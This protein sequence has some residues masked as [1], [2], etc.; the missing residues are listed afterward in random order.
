MTLRAG[1]LAP[2]GYS[3]DYAASTD[4]LHQQVGPTTATTTSLETSDPRIGFGQAV[5]FTAQVTAV[6]G[7]ELPS[8][9]LQF[10]VDDRTVGDPVELVDGRAQTGPVDNLPVGNHKVSAA[11]SGTMH[12]YSASDVTLDGGETVATATTT[13]EVTSSNNP[14]KRGEPEFPK[15]TVRVGAKGSTPTGSVTFNFDSYHTTV[16]LVTGKR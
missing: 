3:P 12:E 4:A 8:G 6:T 5:R 14:Y 15:F 10:A 1:F 16:S 13:T 2:S 7:D 9:T 11:Y